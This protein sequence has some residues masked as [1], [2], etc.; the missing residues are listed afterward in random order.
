[1]SGTSLDG[2]DLVLVTF[3]TKD[4]SRFKIIRSQ[5][6]VYS[7]EWKSALSNA[8]YLD[9]NSLEKLDNDYGVFLGEAC[10]TFIKSH[11]LHADLIASH[12][13]TVFHQP[14]LGI[15]RQIGRGSFLRSVT[16]IPL[17]NNFREQD[18]KLGGQGAPLVPFGDEL[19]F[20][21]YFACLNLGGFANVSWNSGGLR[22]ACDIG[23]C[24]MLFNTLAQKLNKDYDP[25][26][27][28]A[29][30]GKIISEVL[31]RWNSL[32]FYAMDYP[33]SLGREWFEKQFLKYLENN[34]HSIEDLLCTSVEHL[35]IQTNHLLLRQL[36]DGQSTTELRVLCTGG[37]AYNDYLM[38]RLQANANNRLHYI[39]AESNLIDTKEALIFA[40]LGLMKWQGKVNIYASVTGA[41]YDHSGGDIYP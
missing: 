22:Y 39:K 2:L 24:N 31:D 6:I 20:G 27:A 41:K 33:K 3:D 26:G 38:N 19:L 18:V 35:A 17:V 9:A 15:T 23:P 25:E 32:E 29:R 10:N 5:T 30:S 13:H 34:D 1:M 28:I 4:P 12:G 7:Q 36:K 37:G 11:D 14:Y 40:L 8:I 16:G 21:N